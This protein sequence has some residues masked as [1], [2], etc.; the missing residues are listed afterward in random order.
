MS[1]HLHAEY[2]VV[3]VGAG[4]AGCEAALAS[5]RMG[6][7]TALVTMSA[8][9]IARMSCNP[10]I[11]GIAKSHLVF[12]LDALGGEMARNTDYTGIQ[13]R[14]LNTSKGP[15]VRANRAQCD[16]H[17][18]HLRMKAVI[19]SQPGL[20]LIEGQAVSVET[21]RD[22]ISGVVL[23][24]GHVLKADA[25]VL[26]P[27]TFLNGTMHVGHTRTPGGRVGEPASTELVQSLQSLGFQAG[28]LKTGT[29]ARLAR[30][31]VDYSKMDAQPGMTPPPLFS[32][33][34]RRELFHVE[35]G[36]GEVE[37]VH[38]SRFTVARSAV[39]EMFHVEHGDG[40]VGGSAFARRLRR[41]SHGSR[42]TVGDGASVAIPWRPGEDQL[43]CYLTHTTPETHRIIRENLSRSALYGGAITGTGVRYC[44]SIE[45]KIVKFADKDRHHVFVEPEGR[46]CDTVYPNGTSNSLP[47][48]V[49]L[50]MLHSIP[51]FERAEVVKWAY[52]IEY[53]FFD[54]TQLF[55]TLE[56]K[57]VNGLYFAGQI[58]GTTG[59]EEAGAQ[60][61]MAG[62]NAAASVLGR[63]PVVLGR[64][65][66]YIGVLIDDLVTKGT[67]EPY[68]MFT[69][70]AEHRLV[71]R[72]D[73][74]RFRLDHHARQ[75]GIL[76]SE[77]LE[78]TR[79]LATDIQSELIRLDQTRVQ[80]QTQREILR[81]PECMYKD[82]VPRNEGLHREA[83]E[84]VEVE[85][86]Y[87]GY[88][89]RQEAEIARASGLEHTTIPFAFAFASVHGLRK[90]ACEKFT[91][92]KP[93][94]LGQALRIP[95]ISPADIS[96]LSIAMKN[97]ASSRTRSLT[98]APQRDTI[99]TD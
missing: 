61:F 58:N 49:Q 99:L 14:V 35:R 23:A 25:V 87:E 4:H 83:V 80:G 27:G 77:Y 11:G 6:V 64:H 9:S 16:K 74:A 57:L 53:D 17:W 36:D 66:A 90:E 46:D 71:L 38:G 67:M 54:P 86:K 28:R 33:R 43:P 65:E 52:A 84:Q 98:S 69:S 76:P 21:I 32:W 39:G 72:Q 88:I 22:R 31:S 62:I 37:E 78:E 18:Y 15:A 12:E 85:V 19:Q 59:Y 60:G 75:I 47:E 13:F 92:I 93:Q 1:N 81:R 44:P 56:S 3:V 26:C 42:F 2:Q 91:R 55:P 20:S 94:T 79:R 50:A 68:R 5:A 30:T 97:F 89:R 41:T 7:R 82:L 51:G 10:S 45:D 24:D 70:L 8:D 40:R 96:V 34:A 48:D 29:P 73:N 63:Q 95:G